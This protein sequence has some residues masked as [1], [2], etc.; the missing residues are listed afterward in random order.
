MGIVVI[1]GPSANFVVV[2]DRMPNETINGFRIAH[3]SALHLNSTFPMIAKNMA[4]HYTSLYR[5][6]G[7]C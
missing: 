4:E 5:D 1:G 3:Q 6:L 7:R 2:G